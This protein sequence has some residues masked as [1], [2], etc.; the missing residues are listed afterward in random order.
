[1][2]GVGLGIHAL[3]IAAN[4]GGSASLKATPAIGP[5]SFRVNTRV[6]TLTQTRQADTSAVYAGFIRILSRA[7]IPAVRAII[8]SIQQCTRTI[9][10]FTVN[11]C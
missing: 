11:E 6:T 8:V 7:F 1:M 3:P 10:A 9:T 5:V 4:F 2:I